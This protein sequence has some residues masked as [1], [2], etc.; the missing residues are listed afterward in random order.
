MCQ[1]LRGW[2]L[3]PVRGCT[4]SGAGQMATASAAHSDDDALL[5]VARNKQA[6]DSDAGD[7]IL[8]GGAGTVDVVEHRETHLLLSDDHGS[9]SRRTSRGYRGG[10]GPATPRA[11]APAGGPA[12]A[13]T[14]R[15]GRPG[16]P[17]SAVSGRPGRVFQ[18]DGPRQ[19]GVARPPEW[20]LVRP[21][22]AR[23]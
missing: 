21:S 13:A 5:R 14:P 6:G 2:M 12:C 7:H 10:P 23:R 15:Q 3:W 1:S 11:T 4:T 22:S 18:D 19:I 16:L 8:P 20:R 17:I 9:N